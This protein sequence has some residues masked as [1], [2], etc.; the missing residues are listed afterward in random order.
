MRCRS[1]P[2]VT[3]FVI[4]ACSAAR[5][6]APPVAAPG[7]TSQPAGDRSLAY[8][9][10]MQLVVDDDEDLEPA[11]RS[12]AELAS[13][14]EGYVEA[15]AP[16]SIVLRIPSAR[17]EEAMAAVGAQGEISDRWISAEDVTDRRAEL[18]IRAENLRA[19]QA[20]LRE[21]AGQGK[22]VGEL[23]EVEKELARVSAELQ[24]VE[25]E[26]ARLGSRVAYATLSVDLTTSVSPGPV[27]WVF[28]GL[29]A[30]VKWLFVWD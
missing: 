30:G 24:V 29:F 1:L 2:A 13:R 14:L 17:L 9:A 19:F 16:R 26:L 11:V 4:A 28:Y 22:T 15:R 5:S 25:D 21:L 18:S 10:Q 12:L 20:R 8:R 27:G 3:L 23:L 6:G 7:Q